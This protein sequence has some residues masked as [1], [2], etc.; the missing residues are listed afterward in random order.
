MAMLK[1]S[2]KGVSMSYK[3]TGADGAEMAVLKGCGKGQT[4]QVDNAGFSLVFAEASEPGFFEMTNDGAPGGSATR[5]A[6]RRHFVIDQGGRAV[7]LDCPFVGNK[8][9]DAIVDGQ[10]V[11][12]ISLSRFTGRVVTIDLPET[13]PLEVRLF[14]GWLTLRGWNTQAEQ[15]IEV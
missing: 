13:I 14:A 8:P 15:R 11:G 1:L 7:E 5:T 9:Y 10:T 3:V 2:K 4:G 6:G 12:S